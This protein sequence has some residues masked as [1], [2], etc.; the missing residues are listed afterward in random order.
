MGRSLTVIS[1]VARPA[2]RPG[3]GV[4]V[5][6]L[7][8]LFLTAIAF[9]LVAVRFQIR[10]ILDPIRRFNRRYYNRLILMFAGE[11][12][13]LYSVVRHV[14][15][16]SGQRYETPVFAAPVD[17]GFVIALFYGSEVDWLRNLRATGH[18]QIFHDGGEHEIGA[19]EMIDEAA[20]P[21]LP[22]Q[23]EAIVKLF[24]I[25]QYVRVRNQPAVEA[26]SR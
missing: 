5:T 11:R 9:A 18:G 12:G 6:W 25:K 21:S 14:G 8:G 26:G 7:G 20:L 22:W 10:P 4:V 3:S 16:R 24:G 15:R 17:D 13:Q 2:T 19:P 23:W 1:S